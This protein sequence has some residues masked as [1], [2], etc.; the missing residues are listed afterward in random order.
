MKEI[1]RDALFLYLASV[2]PF[3]TAPTCLLIYSLIG[4][5][6]I[7]SICLLMSLI[8]SSKLFSWCSIVSIVDKS[9][10][11]SL[12]LCDLNFRLRVGNVACELFD[13]SCKVCYSY[14]ESFNYSFKHILTR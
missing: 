9:M 8:L 14:L 10:F 6:S 1:N 11:M 7:A 4:A 3:S 13:T 12:S 5:Y 2:Q